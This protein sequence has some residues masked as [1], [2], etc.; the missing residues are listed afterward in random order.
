M[1]LTWASVPLKLRTAGLQEAS[2]P[3]PEEVRVLEEPGTSEAGPFKIRHGS[4]D[5]WG[6]LLGALHPGPC[7]GIHKGSRLARGRLSLRKAARSRS[8]AG[9]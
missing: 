5:T 6:L 3:E 2:P 9:F 8:R 4:S 7:V 1:E